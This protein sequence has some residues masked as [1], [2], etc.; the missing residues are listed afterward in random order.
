MVIFFCRFSLFFFPEPNNIILIFFSRNLKLHPDCCGNKAV[1]LA[2]PWWARITNSIPFF[3]AGWWRFYE[4]MRLLKVY[5]QV[6]AH[7]LPTPTKT[8]RTP[9]PLQIDTNPGLEPLPPKTNRMPLPLQ[10]KKQ[11]RTP[12]PSLGWYLSEHTSVTH[13]HHHSPIHPLPTWPSTHRHIFFTNS[14]IPHKSANNDYQRC[15]G[16][17]HT[18]AES[19]S[20]KCNSNFSP[21]AMAIFT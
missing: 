14:C 5:M 15:I 18:M 4:K 9:L 1:A 16:D 2:C 12:L 11:N 6:H 13:N 3:P 7:P 20:P 10:T 17:R 19:V 21:L 8:N